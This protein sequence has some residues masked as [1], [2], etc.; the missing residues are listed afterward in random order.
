MYKKKPNG[1]LKNIDFIL[2]DYICV[3][4]AFCIAYICT[5]GWKFPYR[6]SYGIERGLVLSL[7][8]FT[9]VFF[10][11]S[12]RGILKRSC[13]QE[14]LACVKQSSVV[15]GLLV[16]Y[17][18]F[19]KPLDQYY[20]STW[21]FMWLFQV[22]LMVFCRSMRKRQIKKQSDNGHGNRS[23][24]L[25]TT[26]HQARD[27]VVSVKKDNYE[28][29]RIAG[30]IILDRDRRGQEVEGVKVVAAQQDALEWMKEQWVDEVLI[31]LSPE[32]RNKGT[33]HELVDGCLKMGITVHKTLAE[34]LGG[35]SHCAVQKIARYT[36]LS[37]SMVMTSTR[38]L[39]LKRVLD[40]C[41]GVAGC[42]VTGIACLIVG[43]WIYA[44]SP[45]PIFFSQ[46][47]VGR[48]GKKF[49]IYKFRSMYMDAEERK[50]ELME[51]NQMQGLMFKM[52]NDPRIIKGVGTLI[53]KTSIDELPQFW[54]VLKGDMSLV[55]TRPPTVDEWD[56]YELHHRGRLAV[57]PGITG[58]WQVS[59]RSKITDFEKVVELDT[60]YIMN[61]SLKMDIK[62]LLKTVQIVLRGDGAA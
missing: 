49:K 6:G 46:V 7:S 29:L 57:K 23:I 10:M 60:K 18:F 44:V 2:I 9:M 30:L 20:R 52:D 3:H 37:N 53:R 33:V 51:K 54:N 15:V 61:Q 43:P 11:Q 27:F 38:Q 39:F 28:F 59:G 16:I 1:W 42:I 50:K 32:E 35:N 26:D 48:N 34:N 31:H 5:H 21:I 22:F 47:R 55:G 40:I 45:G 36:V 12:Y 14:L 8:F 58:M 41:G 62:I 13:G 4:L 24:I 25:V 19:A 17:L 56:R